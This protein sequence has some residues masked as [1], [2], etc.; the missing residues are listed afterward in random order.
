MEKENNVNKST[1]NKKSSI[2]PIM[3]IIIILLIIVIALLAVL[4]LRPPTQQAV[5]TAPRKDPTAMVGELKDK[6]KEEIQAELNK[7]VEAGMFNVKVNTVI[8]YPD[9]NSEGEVRIQNVP[10]NNFSMQVRFILA[11]T[12]ETVY[13][14]GVLEQ[15]QFIEKAK[16][17]VPLKKGTYEATAEFLALDPETLS[18]Q[19]KTNVNIT[20]NVLN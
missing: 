15:N 8:D 11:E 9:G 3:I 14:T 5:A 18:E 17:D 12:G 6:T 19:G 13:T 10:N 2:N 7:V 4:V 20:L 1:E 16:L